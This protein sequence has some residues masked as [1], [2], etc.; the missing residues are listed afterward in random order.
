MLWC[1]L[2]LLQRHPAR[3]DGNAADRSPGGKKQAREQSRTIP[4]R[5][6]VP[7]AGPSTR[8]LHVDQPL[9][10]GKAWAKPMPSPQRAERPSAPSDNSATSNVTEIHQ[11]LSEISRQLGEMSLRLAAMDNWLLALERQSPVMESQSPG[12]QWPQGTSELGDTPGNK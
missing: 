12:P 2:I 10:K 11:T 3:D 7:T 8:P 5:T 4:S 9:P 1:L 6:N